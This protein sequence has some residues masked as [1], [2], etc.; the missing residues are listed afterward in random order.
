MQDMFT[1]RNTPVHMERSEGFSEAFK[2]TAPP[3]ESNAPD[4][5]AASL[6]EA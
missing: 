4:T 2:F 1:Y 5:N 3:Q 6:K